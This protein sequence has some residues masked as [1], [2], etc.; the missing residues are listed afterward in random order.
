ML[1]FIYKEV[2]KLEKTIQQSLF[3]PEMDIVLNDEKTDKIIK[4]LKKKPKEVGELPLDKF[5]KSKNISFSDKLGRVKAEVERILGGYNENTVCIYDRNE[6]HD[7][8]SAAIKNGIIAIDTETLGTRDDI[9]KPATDS[10]TCR[11][12]GLCIYTPG[13]KNAYIPINHV[14]YETGERFENQLTE[15]DVYEELKRVVD[16]KTINLFQNGKF[17]YMVLYYTCGI[18]VPITWDTMIGSQILDENELAG[19]KFQYRDKINPEQEKYDIDK[20]FDLDNLDKYPP[21]LFALYAATDAFMT[22]ELYKYQ[23]KEFE[24]R[25]NEKL[26]SLFLDIEMPVV[27]VT[28]EMQ[29]RGVGIDKEFAQRLSDKYHKKLEPV[30]EGIAREL[31]SYKDIINEWKLTPEANNHPIAPNGKKQK[32]MVEQ[33]SDPIDVNSSK[34]LGI[35]LY[36]ILKVLKPKVEEHKFE[37]TKVKESVDEDTLLTIKDK[38][39]LIPLILKKREYDKYLGTY[40]DALPKMVSPRDDRLHPKFN[41]LGREEGNVVTGRFSSSDPN[42]QNIPAR[43][44]ITSVRC[45][46]V[47][48]TD[49]FTRYS[50]DEID[51]SE[52]LLINDNWVWKNEFRGTLVFPVKTRK[53]YQL[54]GADFSAQEVKVFAQTCGD[55]ILLN[56][57]MNGKDL[58]SEVASK[59]Y[60][61][62]YEEC[63]EFRPDGTFNLEGKARRTKSKSIVLGLMY[64]RGNT[65]IAEQIK[66]HPGP[67]T[68]E[69]RQEAKEIVDTFFNSYPGAKEWVER[70]H[71]QA[72][73]IGYVEDL[74]GRRRRLPDA[75]LPKYEFSPLKEEEMFNPLLGTTSRKVE[76]DPSMITKYTEMLDKCRSQTDREAIIKRAEYDNIKIQSNTGYIATAERQSQNSPIQGGAATMTKI[77]MRNIHFDKELNELDFHLLIPV[78]DELIG[79][80]PLYYIEEAKKRMFYLMCNA[81]K[82]E[83]KLPMK[84]DGDDWCRWYLDVTGQHI[85]DEYEEAIKEGKSADEAFNEVWSNN[86]EFTK[87]QINLILA[88]NNTDV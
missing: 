46:I 14:D 40:I 35:L 83:F 21:E 60:N 39:P 23:K 10:F 88:N 80:A 26:Y 86:C 45:M 79:E 47:P 67:V 8:I 37:R 36:H 25:G 74:W 70:M 64:G 78:H 57:L 4:K 69:D 51:A 65:S 27:T 19:L 48:T 62:P 38:L 50:M 72:R 76:L 55:K 75:S 31:E 54:C 52:E 44:N 42:F 32:S 34:Q 17:D 15:E 63:C 28:S 16:A 22:Y 13:Q 5:L 29:M 12:A 68:K 30:E 73:E 82:P 71:K 20:L 9:E 85:R 41:Q 1:I 3:G 56:S 11:L 6:F 24:K 2:C 77:A 61:M 84:C 59:V 53:R 66:S 58:Y 43:G 33:L 7:Y 87:E 81:G 49:Y 18:K